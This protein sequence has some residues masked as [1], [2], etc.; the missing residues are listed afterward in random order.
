MPCE[1]EAM[2]LGSPVVLLADLPD[3]C[4]SLRCFS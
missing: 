4:I 3:A 1:E 2:E